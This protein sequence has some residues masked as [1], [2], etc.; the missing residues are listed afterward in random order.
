MIAIDSE[1]YI[2]F[3]QSVL[4]LCFENVN[5][6]IFWNV[7]YNAKSR[8]EYIKQISP[9]L[10]YLIEQICWKKSSAIPLKGG[11]RR[12][13]EPIYLFSTNKEGLKLENVESN[14]WEISQRWGSNKKP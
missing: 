10:D 1:E 14:F 4:K 6:Y 13:W 5:G 8:Y 7:S 2:N 3:M 11:M 9:Y 12:A